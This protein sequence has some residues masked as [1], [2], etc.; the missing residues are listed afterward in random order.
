MG[1]AADF[2]VSY[3]STDRT[4]AEWVAWQLEQVGCQVIIQAWDIEPGDN[5][6]ARMR[7]ALEHADRTLALGLGRLLDL[8]VVGARL[9]AAVAVW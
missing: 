8:P 1:Q 9:R 5:L 2:F 6:V 4:W 3:T 7:E